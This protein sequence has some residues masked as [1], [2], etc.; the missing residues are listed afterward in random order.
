MG[1][2]HSKTCRWAP[3]RWE[4][5]TIKFTL[6]LGAGREVPHETESVMIPMQGRGGRRTRTLCVS[7]QIGCAMGCD[8][9]ETAQMGL[10]RNLSAAQIV[11]QWFAARHVVGEEINNIVFMGMGEPMD[12]I[13]EVIAA[14]RVLTDHNG[15]SIPSSKITISTV[16]RIDGIRR[17]S[18]TGRRRRFPPIESCGVGECSG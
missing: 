16:G 17:L 1:G 12:N 2:S 13:E 9:C 10:I 8:F 7:S 11:A 18:R 15:P 3:V 14:I 4:G 6:R 5:E